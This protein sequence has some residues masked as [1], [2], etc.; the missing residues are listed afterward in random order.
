MSKFD[1]VVLVK[2]LELTT[3]KLEESPPVSAVNVSGSA[4]PNTV[5][6]KSETEQV[7]N[8]VYLTVRSKL[9]IL[10]SKRIVRE[11]CST[12]CTWLEFFRTFQAY[13]TQPES[14]Y[15]LGKGGRIAQLNTSVLEYV[16][17]F[18]R[19]LQVYAVSLEPKSRPVV[20]STKRVR[21]K[22]TKLQYSVQVNENKRRKVGPRS[23]PGPLCSKVGT[24][25]PLGPSGPPSVV[26]IKNSKITHEEA[27]A[28][29][30]PFP[31]A[32]PSPMAFHQGPSGPT[33]RSCA[34]IAQRCNLGV[35]DSSNKLVGPVSSTPLK[36][37]PGA[38]TNGR[39]FWKKSSMY[40]PASSRSSAS[41][42]MSVSLADTVSDTHFTHLST[43]NTHFTHL[44][45]FSNNKMNK[46]T[47]FAVDAISMNQVEQKCEVFKS[48]AIDFLK[49][50]VS[51]EDMK[52]VHQEIMNLK[53]NGDY[54]QLTRKAPLAAGLLEQLLCP[55]MM[56]L[57]LE[58][59]TSDD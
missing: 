50:K 10:S 17:T 40:S 11:A 6:I 13:I 19:P 58:R 45:T 51:N 12:E 24:G 27:K 15:I 3:P 57:E 41:G 29:C 54:F 48:Y 55:P 56:Y 30:S 32:T 43:F 9:S 37:T 33:Y 8:V 2:R 14:Y 36:L 1:V 21:M 31:V 44:S 42:G 35:Y 7:G 47:D 18:E 38:S 28:A 59:H 34:E 49:R 5:P 52:V 4:V 22:P 46:D 23:K 25:I 39:T 16:K 26:V 53:Q 20:V